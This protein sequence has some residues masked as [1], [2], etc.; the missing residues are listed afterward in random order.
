MNIHLSG[1]LTTIQNMV[2]GLIALLPNLVV[3]VLFFVLSLFLGGAV[4]TVVRRVTLQHKQHV[5]LG[6][7]L[8]RLTQG[9]IIFI[10]ALIAFAIAIPS[11]KPSQ[12]IQLLG[13]SGVAIGFAFK[14]IFQNF[15]AGML[16]LLTEPF[17]IGDQIV[18]GAF[19]GTVEDIQTRATMIRT[20]DG[21]RVVIPNAELFTGS[22]VVNT[23]FD[24]RR[25]EYEVGIGYGE[26]IDNVK[27]L[28][29]QAIKAVPG[30]VTDPAPDVL[31][32][33]LAPS[34]VNLRARWWSQPHKGEVLKVQDQVISSIF[35][36][37]NRK[38]I[39]M[40]YPTQ[41]VIY[42]SQAPSPTAD[43]AATVKFP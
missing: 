21:R 37:L 25:T 39:D 11:F 17:R 33:A 43:G 34:T 6:L 36:L 30:V 7:L 10:G 4:R 14:D 12:V 1:A 2:N 40:P 27:A 41:T 23:A 15:L 3:A 38:G 35:N 42:N 5:S 24:F 20:Y 13:I 28:M 18:V 19:E 8:G 32:V 16:L 22:V 9:I 29:M 31:T 26:N